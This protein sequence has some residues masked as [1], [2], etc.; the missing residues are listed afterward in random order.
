MDTFIRIFQ[1]LYILVIQ[2]DGLGFRYPF[3]IAQ[4]LGND[5]QKCAIFTYIVQQLGNND[6]YQKSVNICPFVPENV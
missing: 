5:N 4:L 1:H 3:I 6:K 2:R